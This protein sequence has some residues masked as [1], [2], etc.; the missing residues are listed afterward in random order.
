MFSKKTIRDMKM[1]AKAEYPKE[2]CGLVV[3]GQYVPA[4]NTAPNPKQDYQIDP[5]QY[6][7]FMVTGQLQAVVHSHPKGPNYPSEADQEIQLASGLTFGIIYMEEG[8]V[9]DVFFWGDDV[10]AAPLVGRPFRPVVADCYALCRDWLWEEKAIRLPNLLRSDAWWT[11]E[12]DNRFLEG[13]EAIGFRKVEGDPKPGDGLL[14][15]IR[16]SKVNHCA[17]YLENGLILHHLINRLSREEPF[18]RWQKYVHTI[19]RREA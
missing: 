15:Q 1:H 7:R 18:A 13:F 11:G 6:A 16:S 8:G 10:P 19:I 17:V 9:Q 14:M 5:Q 3:D 2:S 4:I 12:E